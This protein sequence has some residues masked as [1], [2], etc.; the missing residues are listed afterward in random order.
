MLRVLRQLA[1]SR[2][3]APAVT[4][5]M[6]YLPTAVDVGYLRHDFE[7]PL[8]GPDFARRVSALLRA[9]HQAGPG[10]AELSDGHTCSR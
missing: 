2:R 10:V 1:R 4:D 9:S 7:I 8:P 6:A 5:L 3:R